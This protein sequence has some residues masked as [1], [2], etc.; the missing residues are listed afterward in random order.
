MRKMLW[1]GA[2]AFFGGICGIGYYASQNSTIN[3][4]M[5]ARGVMSHRDQMPVLAI[6]SPKGASSAPSSSSEFKSCDL[7]TPADPVPVVSEPAPAQ[8]KEVIAAGNE[9]GHGTVVAVKMPPEKSGEPMA[10]SED[11]PFEGPPTVKSGES[12]SKKEVVTS[13]ASP[14]FMPYSTEE[15]EPSRAMPM[16]EEDGHSPVR[17][18]H[19]T[20]SI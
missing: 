11:V 12:T 10:V 15:E 17:T 4:G 8:A 2:A 9:A 14:R 19:H 5:P 1:L 6:N 20:R 16:C 3:T 13:N 18:T 7:I